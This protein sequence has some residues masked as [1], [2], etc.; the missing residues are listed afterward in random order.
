MKRILG[1]AVLTLA[2]SSFA[3]GQTTDKK[4]APSGTAEQEPMQVGKT[5]KRS[6]GEWR[7]VSTRPP[8]C[9]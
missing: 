1:V 6:R 4:A 7:C 5:D 3:L 9:R 8:P 2:A